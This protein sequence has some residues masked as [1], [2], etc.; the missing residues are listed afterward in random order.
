MQISGSID[1]SVSNPRDDHYKTSNTDHHSKTL[2]G[3]RRQQ[4][5]KAINIAIPPGV[6]IRNRLL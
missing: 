4:V 2:S 5:A 6:V 1:Q 3:T